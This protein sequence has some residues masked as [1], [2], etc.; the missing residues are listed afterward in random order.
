MR[1]DL[2]LALV[3]RVEPLKIQLGLHCQRLVPLAVF[4]FPPPHPQTQYN[5]KEGLWGFRLKSLRGPDREFC[6]WN[7]V[8]DQAFPCRFSLFSFQNA[9]GRL[10][11]CLGDGKERVSPP[12][13]IL[14]QRGMGALAKTAVPFSASQGP[15]GVETSFLWLCGLDPCKESSF[16]MACPLWVLTALTHCLVLRLLASAGGLNSLLLPLFFNGKGKRID[17]IL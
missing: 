12:G 9:F 3:L 8:K 7:L 1:A 15:A 14:P 11:V 2:F 10:Q 13:V 4:C 5:V 6:V 17:V 16:P